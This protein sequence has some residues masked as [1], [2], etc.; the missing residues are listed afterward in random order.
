MA[1]GSRWS[2]FVSLLP[3]LLYHLLVSSQMAPFGRARFE[4]RQ[5]MS[6]NST[7]QEL[8]ISKAAHAKNFS[9][10][11]ASRISYLRMMMFDDTCLDTDY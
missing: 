5:A 6:W 10:L 4:A 9:V 1:I 11:L 3:K 8:A 2:A 7:K